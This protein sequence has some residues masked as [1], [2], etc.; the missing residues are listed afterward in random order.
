[1]GSAVPSSRGELNAA[2]ML[3][4]IQTPVAET[5]AAA[6]V[7]KQAASV[8]P[9]IS[10]ESTAPKVIDDGRKPSEKLFANLRKKAEA[11]EEKAWNESGLNREEAAKEQAKAEL[12]KG[13]AEPTEKKKI[14]PWKV[15]DEHKAARAKL[16]AENADLKK[17]VANPDVRKQEIERLAA[18]EKRNQELEETIKFVDYS[19]SK[20]FKEKFQEPYEKAWNR[21]MSELKELTV[22]DEET[23]DERSMSPSDLLELVNLPLKK[24]RDKAEELYGASAN[25]VM[26][27]RKEIRGIYEAQNTAL[28][29][30]KKAGVEKS[31]QD[32]V[33]RQERMTSIQ[34]EINKQWEDA[35]K[36][37]LGNEAT[38]AYFKKVE[39][40]EE[41]NTRLERGYKFVDE[42]M[43]VNPMNPDLTPEQRADAVKRHAA[44]RHRAAAFGRMRLEIETM[45]KEYD[46]AKAKLAQYEGSVPTFGGDSK[47]TE[48]ATPSGRGMAGLMQRLQAKA[49]N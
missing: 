8:K 15:I 44:L 40:N 25:E 9:P 28:E 36:S 27:Y 49:V 13:P 3:G 31:S 26:A 1:M 18:I 19:K 48:S 34:S 33:Q 43:A 23:G 29:Q 6:A 4:S 30:A 7:P 16:E 21:A 14:N 10:G 39:G 24:A 17:I 11:N 46:E 5:P 12:A 47:G 20:E 37:F 42:T 22:V 41:V 35:N 32:Q 38:A 2:A 45:R